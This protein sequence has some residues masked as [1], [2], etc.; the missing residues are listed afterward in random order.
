MSRLHEIPPHWSDGVTA[1]HYNKMYPV[2]IMVQYHSV[3]TRPEVTL[4]AKTRAKAWELKDDEKTVMVSVEG[5]AGGLWIRALSIEG[6]EPQHPYIKN[7]LEDLAQRNNTP[8]LLRKA[9]NLLRGLVIPHH[10]IGGRCSHCEVNRA[11]IILTESLPNTIELDAERREALEAL[12]KDSEIVN[13][14]MW[15]ADTPYSNEEHFQAVR[16]IREIH[17]PAL[18]TPSQWKDPDHPQTKSLSEESE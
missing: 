6:Q 4:T 2:G 9:T 16:R 10:V 3:V 13:S 8:D 17:L 7:K 15:Y 5:K 11:L 1:E 12:L 14:Y 18:G